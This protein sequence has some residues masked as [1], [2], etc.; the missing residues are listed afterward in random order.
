MLRRTDATHRVIFELSGTPPFRLDLTVWA[1]RRRPDNSVDQWD[2]RTY[3]RV[4][5]LGGAPTS[6]AIRQ[7]GLPDA[8]RLQVTVNASPAL[9]HAPAVARLLRQV[10]GL[11]IDLSDFYQCASADPSLKPLAERFR[12]LKPPRFPTL[13]ETLVGAIACQ[14][15]TLTLGIRL[16][17][18]L[19]AMGHVR[20]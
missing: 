7:V 20:A 1:L 14:Q 10:L 16:L 6:M 8:A 11:H 9:D 2:R 17:N 5:V 15:I 4:L 3:R 19:A 18:R 13:F 12:G